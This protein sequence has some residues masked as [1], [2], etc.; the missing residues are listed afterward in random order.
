MA[1]LGN[2]LI[3]LFCGPGGLDEGFK[4]AGFIT[5]VAVDID[6]A[7]LLTHQR[8]HPEARHYALDLSCSYAAVEIFRQWQTWFAEDTPVGI[9][10]GPP[11][12]SFSVG[13]ASE[14]RLTD[15]RNKL[16]RAYARIIAELNELFK[17]KISFFVFE[18][19]LPIKKS[20]AYMDF[21]DEVAK[22]GFVV[23]E[24]ELNAVDFGVPQ[25]RK[26]LFI[27]GIN[28]ERHKRLASKGFSFPIGYSCRLP[29]GPILQGIDHEPVIANSGLTPE[30]IAQVAG[31][32]NHWCM[33]PTSPRF[34]AKI[35]RK[36]LDNG[37]PYAIVQ[38][39]ESK[40][41]TLRKMNGKSFKILDPARPSYTIAYGHREVHFHPNEHRRLSVYEAMLLQGFPRDYQFVGSLSDQI[42][43]VSE[44]VPPPVARA[45]AVAIREQ[46]RIKPYAEN[47]Q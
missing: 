28:G 27:V 16:P 40:P 13:N 31:H 20:Q 19:V 35:V 24:Q 6:R 1:P 26:R 11:C 30:E 18:N 10:G 45:L 46:L 41:P 15:P 9:I 29:C 23:F 8:N 5:K 36:Q 43:L 34:R 38:V 4:Q 44:V 17:R 47:K 22:A 37:K 33:E 12:Q 32:P 25:E 42:R 2:S 7:A 39:D 3:S 21:K 14:A